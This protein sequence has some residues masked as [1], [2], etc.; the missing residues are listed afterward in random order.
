M[1]VKPFLSDCA[2]LL[3][4]KLSKT[5]ENNKKITPLLKIPSV[6]IVVLLYVT[7]EFCELFVC[8]FT[9]HCCPQQ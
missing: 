7:A 6:Q 1:S 3:E 4:T 9:F 8:L 2:L 5:W